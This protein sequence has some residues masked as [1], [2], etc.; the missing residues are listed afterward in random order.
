MKLFGHLVILLLAFMLTGCVS[1]KLYGRIENGNRSG[2]V[3]YPLRTPDPK[4]ADRIDDQRLIVSWVLL[5]TVNLKK[6]PCELYAKIYTSSGH[7]FEQYYKIESHVSY[8]VYPWPHDMIKTRG[9]LAA[10]KLEI[11]QIGGS[12]PPKILEHYEHR[13]FRS[14]IT[15]K[16]L[17]GLDFEED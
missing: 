12:E 6:T 4:L 15:E 11:R 10:Y 3:S 5:P 9:R 2:L 13:L 16:D 7:H 17:Q 8:W 14:Q 1:P